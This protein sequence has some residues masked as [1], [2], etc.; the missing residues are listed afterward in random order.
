M[1]ARQVAVDVLTAARTA[2]AWAAEL[3]D[4]HLTRASLSPQDRRFVTQL[5]DSIGPMIDIPA[6]D[7]YTDERTMA[8]IFD[9]YD[10]THKGQNNLPVVTGKP[11]ELGGSL[12]RSTATARGALV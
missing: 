8:W 3:V 11:L 10:M 2:N 9:T 7:V 4:D 5:G 12:G 1:T 6:P